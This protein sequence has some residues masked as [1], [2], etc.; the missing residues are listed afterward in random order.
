VPIMLPRHR[1]FLQGAPAPY[2]RGDLSHDEEYAF[3]AAGYLCVPSVLDAAQVSGLSVA[4]DASIAAHESPLLRKA[5]RQL[6]VNPTSVWYLNQLVGPGFRLDTEPELLPEQTEPQRL[7]GGAVPRRPEDAFY[8]SRL[9][10]RQCNSV[11]VLFAL[12]EVRAGDGGYTLVPCSHCVNVAAPE[13]VLSGLDDLRRHGEGI[14]FQPPM[15][16]GDMLIV[17]GACLQ[18]MRPWRGRQPQRLLSLR[19]VGRSIVGAMGP[20]VPPNPLAGEPWCGTACFKCRVT[21][22]RGMQALQTVFVATLSVLAGAWCLVAEVGA[23]GRHSPKYSARRLGAVA[24]AT[25]QRVCLPRQS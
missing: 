4:L 11:R 8:H 10:R 2:A 19:F 5:V 9:G 24:V 22:M 15:R 20:S 7:S 17:A 18:G 25:A 23:G 6:L 3:Q 12:E 1:D 16:A 13:C 21:G 14:I